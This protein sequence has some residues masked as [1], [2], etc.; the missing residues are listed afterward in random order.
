MTQTIQVDGIEECGCCGYHHRPKFRGDCRQDSEGLIHADAH[1]NLVPEYIDQ[2]GDGFVSR[3]HVDTLRKARDI[4]REDSDSWCREWYA[5]DRDKKHVSATDRTACSWCIS[6]IVAKVLEIA[7]YTESTGEPDTPDPTDY[8]ISESVL[9]SLANTLRSNF[10]DYV[11]D[12]VSPN[13]TDV[14]LVF[15]VNDLGSWNRERSIDL[16]ESALYG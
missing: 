11:S 3:A 7:T 5:M 13:T 2:N 16:F 14:H 6:G 8:R 1:P 9:A 12:T 4:Y 10:A 15:Q